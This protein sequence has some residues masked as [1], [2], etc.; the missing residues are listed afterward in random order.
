MNTQ[1]PLALLAFLLGA[2]LVATPAVAQE[3]EAPAEP[4]SYV[5]HVGKVGGAGTDRIRHRVTR[6]K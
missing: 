5:L 6:V 3:I 4:G 2:L 1:L